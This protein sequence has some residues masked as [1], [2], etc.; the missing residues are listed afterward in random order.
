MG[1]SVPGEKLQ[2]G[3]AG[4]HVGVLLAHVEQVGLVRLQGA[5]AHC[6]MPVESGPTLYLPF[7]QAWPPGY[8]AILRED[9]RAEFEA[10]VKEGRCPLGNTPMTVAI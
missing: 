10:H 5:V 4:H 6:D 8:L 9:V 7:S 2:E 1:F 3:V